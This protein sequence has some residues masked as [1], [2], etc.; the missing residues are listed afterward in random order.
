LGMVVVVMGD[1]DDSGRGMWC[2]LCFHAE[3]KE[4]V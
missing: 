4:K 2:G 3:K 1:G